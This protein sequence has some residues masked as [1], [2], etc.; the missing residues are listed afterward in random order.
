[1]TEMRRRE[2]ERRE[3]LLLMSGSFGDFM[4]HILHSSSRYSDK[5]ERMAKTFPKLDVRE[6]ILFIIHLIY[7]I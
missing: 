7:E 6:P 1:M 3:H 2:R 4:T 5:T